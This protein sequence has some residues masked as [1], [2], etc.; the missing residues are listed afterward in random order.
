V[1]AEPGSEGR[2]DV[3]R[4]RK[5]F[6]AIRK[7]LVEH[8]LTGRLQGARFAIYIWLHLQADHTTGTVWTNAAKLA[9]EIGFHPSTVRAALGGLRRDGYIAY[10]SAD[11][12]RRLYAIRIAKYHEHFEDDPAAPEGRL[13]TGRATGGATGRRHFRHGTPRNH[14]ANDSPKKKEERSKTTRSSYPAG[15]TRLR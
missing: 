5:P 6:T 15:V 2:T 1:T 3:A 9:P 8:V 7:G 4:R 10:A 13:A 12:D 14:E 11:G